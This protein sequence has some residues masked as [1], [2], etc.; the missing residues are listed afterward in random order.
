MVIERHNDQHMDCMGDISTILMILYG[1]GGGGGG[2]EKLYQG[3]IQEF[4]KGG[5]KIKFMKGE[6]TGGGAPPP[7]AG[8]GAKPQ[9]LFKFS[10]YLA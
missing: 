6:G 7:V 3:R 9:P 1:G 4:R 5:S 8:S 10:I 2:P